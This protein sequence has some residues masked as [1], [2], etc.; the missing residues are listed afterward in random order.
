[1]DRETDDRLN[2][3][4]R[5]LLERSAAELDSQSVMRLRAARAR[6]LGPRSGRPGW[7]APVTGVAAL[8]SAVLAVWLAFQPPPGAPRLAVL[9][10]DT[11]TLD[12]LTAADDF[13][14]VEDLEFYHWLD[15]RHAG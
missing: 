13:E 2:E 14:L 5:A 3:R 11:E 12:L 1:M 4:A 9:E 15:D 6:A 8:V 10:Q 7:L